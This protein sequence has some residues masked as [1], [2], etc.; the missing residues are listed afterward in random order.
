MIVDQ[1]KQW[2][3]QAE[4]VLTVFFMRLGAKE[5]PEGWQDDPTEEEPR[6]ADQEQTASQDRH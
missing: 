6:P 4:N 5:A 3:K 2:E 1:L